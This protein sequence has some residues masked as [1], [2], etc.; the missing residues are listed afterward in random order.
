MTSTTILI[1]T[2]ILTDQPILWCQT[3]LNCQTYLIII[4][5]IIIISVNC[6]FSI[7]W[8]WMLIIIRKVLKHKM[9]EDGL[10]LLLY[11]PPFQSHRN[12][13]DMLIICVLLGVS[14][15]ALWQDWVD[16][17]ALTSHHSAFHLEKASTHCI[18]S[19]HIIISSCHCAAHALHL[20]HSTHSALSQMIGQEHYIGRKYKIYH[21]AFQLN[22]CQCWPSSKSTIA[23]FSI[24]L[25]S[26]LLQPLPL[27]YQ[28]SDVH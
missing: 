14:Q 13:E 20:A 17:V 8:D 12:G 6:E 1:W 15:Q 22:S 19:S 28:P 9:N 2:S 25:E 4:K 23:S 16:I 7:D 18:S 11:F 10:C 27:S 24:H 3:Y 5:F 21:H 26:L